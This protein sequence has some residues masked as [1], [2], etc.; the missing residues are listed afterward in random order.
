MRNIKRGFVV[1]L[2]ALVLPAAACNVDT[3][4]EDERA[5]L[6]S[7]ALG[8]LP[9]SPS[10][11]FADNAEA[12][13]LGQQ[14]F[15]D[16]RFSGELLETSELGPAGSPALVAC[17]TCHDPGKGGAD[18]RPLG[19]T[20][21]GAAWTGRNAPSVLNAAYS[22]WMMW[23]GR[24][25]S[26]WSQALGPIEGTHEHNT[27]RLHLVRTIYEKYR[28]PYE[29]LFGPMPA[30]DDLSRFPPEGKPGMAAFDNMAAADKVAINR[31][32]SNF[33]KAIEAYERRLVD[34]S[35][36]FDRFLA[37]DQGGEFTPQ[38]LRGAKLFV[39]K[40][41]C[42]ECHSGSTMA[43]GKFHNHGV[44]QH[45]VKIP[46]TDR[47]RSDGIPE[48]LA[49]EFN[50]A[51]A[52]SDMNKADR[53]S[54]LHTVDGDLG[55]FKTPTLRN[56]ARTGPFMHTGG[57]ANLW[58]VVNW[59]NQAAGTDGFAGRREAAS[60]VPLKLTDEE[61]AD[62]VEFLKSLDGDPLPDSLIQQPTLP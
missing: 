41:A 26:Q 53:W 55:A 12:A 62:L 40:A 9:P 25:D 19:G 49:D 42:N 30:M 37:G 56:V 7:M 48:L 61:M 23:D 38:M 15:F 3:L 5:H 60:L 34:K 43:D 20:S 31:V 2:A 50:T 47:G 6:Q 58:D 14:F 28:Q 54:G 1:S 44:P 10:N 51:G 4:T 17:A 16:A 24:R 27:T 52:Y 18:P 13:Q 39:G 35:S 59:Y 8:P 45:G 36:K 29:R 57:F 33:G 46:A 21:L 22:P 32:F 11:T